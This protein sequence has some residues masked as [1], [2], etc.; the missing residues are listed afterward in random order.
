MPDQYPVQPDGGPDEGGPAGQAM[1]P[2]GKGRTVAAPASSRRRLRGRVLDWAIGALGML[3]LLLLALLLFWLSITRPAGSADATPSVGTPMPSTAGPSADATP[4]SDL[5]EDEV[6]LG[7]ISLEA[8]STD[9]DGR[10]DHDQVDHNTKVSDVTSGPEAPS[11]CLYSG[12]DAHLTPTGGA[13]GG[14]RADLRGHDV[15]RDRGRQV[16]L[17]DLSRRP[18]AAGGRVPRRAR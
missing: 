16:E 2:G 7:D 11:Q 10:R 13:Q 15:E 17:S 5:A 14:V 3:G 4:P 1:P 12:V 9:V 8:G 6:W 18:A